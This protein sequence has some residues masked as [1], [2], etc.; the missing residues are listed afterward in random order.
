LGRQVTTVRFDIDL[1]VG[2]N[3]TGTISI[4]MN[5]RNWIQITAGVRGAKPTLLGTR[6]TP[7]DILEYLARG[8]D[9]RSNP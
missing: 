8:D 6:I 1:D 2:I 9:R 4:T 3:E 7:T 5:W